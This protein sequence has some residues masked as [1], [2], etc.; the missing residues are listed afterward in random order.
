MMFLKLNFMQGMQ[1]GLTTS[2]EGQLAL[3]EQIELTF[4]TGF[5]PQ[6]PAGH[7]VNPSMI[8]SD[9]MHDEAGIGIAKPSDDNAKGLFHEWLFGWKR[10]SPPSFGWMRVLGK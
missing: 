5:G 3:V 7:G 8:L 9:P 4:E 10:S 6:R 1:R 2:F